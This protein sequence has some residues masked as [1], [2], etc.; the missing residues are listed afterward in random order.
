MRKEEKWQVNKW[1]DRWMGRWADSW[2]REQEGRWIE[3]DR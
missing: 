2:I 3:M 1:V